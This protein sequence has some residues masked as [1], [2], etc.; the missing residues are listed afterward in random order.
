VEIIHGNGLLN[1]A[2]IDLAH[3]IVHTKFTIWTKKIMDAQYE[4]YASLIYETV[5][6]NTVI[7]MLEIILCMR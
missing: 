3:G 2:I 5:S 6:E 7:L 1:R 4:G